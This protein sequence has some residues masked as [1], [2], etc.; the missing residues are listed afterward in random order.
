MYFHFC[1]VWVTDTISFSLCYRKHINT[2]DEKHTTTGDDRLSLS[3]GCV[4]EGSMM[5]AEMNAFHNTVVTVA[6][7][8]SDIADT[9]LTD[10]YAKKKTPVYF[11]IIN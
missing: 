9:S 8:G 4:C 6:G 1:C 11:P 2:S 5:G 7:R 3:S 10:L